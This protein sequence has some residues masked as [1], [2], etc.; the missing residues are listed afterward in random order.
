M[1]TGNNNNPLAS[2]N[3]Q[4]PLSPTNKTNS[5]ATNP[6]HSSST[7]SG[8]VAAKPGAGNSNSL[9]GHQSGRSKM[10]AY[11]LLEQQGLNLSDNVC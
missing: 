2:Q 8:S 5:V 7:K 1:T 10:P 6:M 9:P 3:A 4:R 11:N